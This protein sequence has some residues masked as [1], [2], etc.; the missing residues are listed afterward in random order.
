MNQYINAFTPNP[1]CI[2]H[3][4][5]MTPPAPACFFFFPAASFQHKE[6]AA[7]FCGHRSIFVVGR[8]SLASCS[9]QSRLS[10][11]DT[12]VPDMFIKCHSRYCK[13]LQGLVAVAGFNTDA[14]CG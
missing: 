14:G 5:I 4:F 13:S 12:N 6:K 8:H 10:D 2:S 1:C 7:D 9:C 11:A 3:S